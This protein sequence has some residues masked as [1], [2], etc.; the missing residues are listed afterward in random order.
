MTDVVQVVED[1]RKVMDYVFGTT[2]LCRELSDATAAAKVHKVNCVTTEGD[3]VSRGGPIRG[4]RKRST[5][6]LN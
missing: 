5:Q 2:I 1:Y 3:K 6:R 4:E